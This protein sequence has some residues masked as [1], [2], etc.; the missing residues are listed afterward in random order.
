ML[1]KDRDVFKFWLKPME[2]FLTL[3]NWL[4][5]APIKHFQFIILTKEESLKIKSEILSLSE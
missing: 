1:D 2:F 4:K 3:K 5:P